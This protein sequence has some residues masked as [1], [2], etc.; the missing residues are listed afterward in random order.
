MSRV[1]NNFRALSPDASV[2][3]I[4]TL[5]QIMTM[6]FKLTITLAVERRLSLSQRNL[7]AK[8]SGW[9]QLRR[10]FAFEGERLAECLR[11]NSRVHECLRYCLAIAWRRVR[12]RLARIP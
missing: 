11:H 3:Q 8:L 12:R 7:L 10:Y 6:Q 1:F 5:A 4:N 2:I 9:L